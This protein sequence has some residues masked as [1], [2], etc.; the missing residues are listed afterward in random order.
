MAEE[1]IM[2]PTSET[3]LDTLADGH[4][5]L[6]LTDE[7]LATLHTTH[8]TDEL[9]QEYVADIL[10]Q[11]KKL[12]LAHE[13]EYEKIGPRLL[14]VSRAC[15]KRIYL[16]GLAWRW[17][18]LE[19]YAELA[20]AN[21]RTVCNFPDW[22]PSHFL[23]TAEM[24]QAVGVGYDW[25]YSYWDEETRTF[26]RTRLIELGL[27]PGMKLYEGQEWPVSNSHNW[28]QVC[29]G[30]M[31]TGAL[32]IAGEAPEYAR[33]MVP[34]AVKLLPRALRSYNPD[35]VWPEGPGYW[36]YATQYT[37]YGL[38]ALQSALGTDFG[39]SSV[40]GLASAGR[41]PLYMTGPTG[42][43]LNYADSGENQRRGSMPC[44]LWLAQVFDDTALADAEHA[45]IKAHGVFPEHLIWYQPPS[46]DAGVDP[47]LDQYLR[48][49]VDLAVFRSAWED[50]NALFVGVKGGYNQ[51]NHGHLDLG[52]F[53]MDAL[54][55]RWA[56][57]LGSDDY[58]MPDYWDS[59]SGGKRWA[60]YRLNSLSHNVL[61]LGGKNQ[62][63][64]GKA[65]VLR[66]QLNTPEPYVM[67]D[68]TSAYG[69][70]ASKVTRGL[71]LVGGRRATLV[72]DECIL[73]Q[74]C[75]VSWGMTTDAEIEIESPGV[76]LLSLK[77]RK[78][79]ARILSPVDATF[80]IESAEQEPP[81]KTNKGVQRLMVH[82]PETAGEVRIAVLLSP[83]WPGTEDIRAAELKALKDW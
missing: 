79:H 38:G 77:G 59:K 80:S 68:L 73:P 24:T 54:G 67:L 74:A 2:V 65:R 69:E 66:Q 47:A 15:L 60:Y 63:A 8:G 78:L 34:E 21:L 62:D 31:I 49:D 22:N 27:K 13:L 30:G 28:N 75:A 35:G 18:G 19:E 33:F 58:N 56:R 20:T 7:T 57:D 81:Q 43:L 50:S 40:E 37:A 23:D 29:N 76:A 44:L 41:F 25:L 52:N 71:A 39:L 55:V 36:H 51:V 48:S 45:T 42:L 14:H 4:P 61:L 64:E 83:H 70:F 1:R 53:E 5:R 3:V 6:L 32:A 17:T 10:R 12:S 26:F 46:G 16:L 11:A 9:L 82:L 72:Q